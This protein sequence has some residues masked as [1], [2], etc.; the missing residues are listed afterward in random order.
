MK[1]QKIIAI[2]A[3]IMLVGFTAK[4][5]DKKTETVV[6]QTSAK[7][8]QCKARIERDLM[9]E[10][11]V[12]SVS[13]DNAT[14]MVTVEYRVDKTNVERIKLAITKIGYDADDMVADQ[15]AHDNLP[16]CCQKT[17]DPH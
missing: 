3:L 7:C 11:G 6:I 15:K 17:A 16:A 4:A 14:K 5:Q 1:T 9:F 8:G 2:L 10:K 13:L 12:K